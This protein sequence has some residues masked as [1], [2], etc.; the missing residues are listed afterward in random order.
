MTFD[1]RMEKSLYGFAHS[2]LHVLLTAIGNEPSAPLVR[3]GI[4][5]FSVLFFSYS[6]NG[7][8]SST[9]SDAQGKIW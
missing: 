7:E 4:Q 2:F 3:F 6:S 1:Y 5:F 9:S 8:N